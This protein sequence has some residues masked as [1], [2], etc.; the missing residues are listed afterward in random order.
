[1]FLL[2]NKNDEHDILSNLYEEIYSHH[3]ITSLSPNR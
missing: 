1:M 2:I 3:W